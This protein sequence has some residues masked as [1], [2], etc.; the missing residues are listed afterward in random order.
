MEDMSVLTATTQIVSAAMAGKTAAV[1]AETGKQV[2]GFI[3]AV[4][5]KLYELKNKTR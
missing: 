4:Y 5:E 1:N 2:S 3:E